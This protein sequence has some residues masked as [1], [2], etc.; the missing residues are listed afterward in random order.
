MKKPKDILNKAIEA[1][2]STQV[3]PGPPQELLDATITKLTGTSGNPHDKIDKIKKFDKIRL[4][5]RLIKFAAAAVLMLS[6]GYTIGRLWPSRAPNAEQLYAALEPAIRRKVLEDV[7]R[8]WL[9]ALANSYVQLKDELQQQYRSELSQLAI[10]VLAATNTVTNQ[11]LERLIEAINATQMQQRDWFTAALEQ[12]ELNRLR[13]KT[14]LSNSLES[15]AVLTAD[16][17][18]QTKQD[19]VQLLS[20]ARPGSLVPNEFR[21]SN[22]TNEGSEQ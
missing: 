2:A 22:N 17:L 19:M 5:K 21:N 1:L 4:A 13:D 11:R 9:V 18:M 20:Y 15:L 16:E 8:Y 12:I 7:Q 6:A 3:P 10:R 14:R